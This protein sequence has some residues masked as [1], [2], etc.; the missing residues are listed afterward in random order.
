MINFGYYIYGNEPL[1]LIILC[2]NELFLLRLSSHKLNEFA[3]I[4]IL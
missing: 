2:V 3:S 4:T 1:R